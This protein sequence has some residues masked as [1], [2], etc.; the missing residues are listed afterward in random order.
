MFP[1]GENRNKHI[2]VDDMQLRGQI[3]ATHSN[4][5]HD[6]HPYANK[7]TFTPHSVD[8]NNAN[9]IVDFYK[10]YAKFLSNLNVSSGN[11][12]FFEELSKLARFLKITKFLLNKPGYMGRSLAD[13]NAYAEYDISTMDGAVQLFEA[14]SGLL[15]P[16]F[17][18]KAE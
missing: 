7:V 17:R 5:L 13:V 12:D 9:A 8:A 15:S 18:A 16:F 1:N 2:Y 10:K 3:D 11:D 4:P 6:G 14:I